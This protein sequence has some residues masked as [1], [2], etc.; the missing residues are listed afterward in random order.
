MIKTKSVSNFRLSLTQF[1]KTS[2]YYIICF[3]TFF[4]N[5]IE[6]VNQQWANNLNQK[7]IFNINQVLAIKSK[8]TSIPVDELLE[9][10]ETQHVRYLILRD[11]TRI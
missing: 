3:P 8:L 1:Y 4:L 11:K 9:N 7:K 2:N 5:C 6:I 10:I